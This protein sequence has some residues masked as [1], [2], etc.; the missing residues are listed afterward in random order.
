MEAGA[1]RLITEREL[2]ERLG[3]RVAAPIRIGTLG[4]LGLD[5]AAFLAHLA[6]HFEQ[7]GDDEYLRRDGMLAALREGLPEEASGIAAVAMSFR[8]GAVGESALRGFVEQLDADARGRYDASRHVTRQRAIARFAVRRT[9]DEPDVTRLPAGDF[10]QNVRDARGATRVFAEASA[11]AVEAPIVTEVLCAFA[12]LVFALHPNTPGLTM[13]VHLMRSLPHAGRLAENSPEGVHEDGVD[14]IVSALVVA[15]HNVRGGVSEVHEQL[16]D[17]TRVLL[18]E[19]TLE[20]GE[21]I[22]QADTGE[23]ARFGNDLW[24]YVTPMAL[25]DAAEAGWRDILGIDIEL[26]DE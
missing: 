1:G 2:S 3:R 19:Q 21:F 23:E 4:M 26:A 14:Y 13:T 17:G 7:L 12:K 9:E 22:F 8:G 5:Q 24:H 20:P 25:T 10:R 15:R 6:P 16:P 18:H 11:R